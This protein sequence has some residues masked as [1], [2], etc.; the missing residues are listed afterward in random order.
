MKN[1]I[2]SLLQA[3]FSAI[4]PSSKRHSFLPGY[5]VLFGCFF[6][7]SEQQVALW[8]EF[9]V[10]RSQGNIHFKKRSFN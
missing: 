5:R 7:P 8:N 2:A 1:S 9:I 6:F 3:M 4:L 10:L